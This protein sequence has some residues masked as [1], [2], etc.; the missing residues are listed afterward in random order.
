[1][2]IWVQSGSALAKGA[3][4]GFG[5]GDRYE[6]ALARHFQKVARPGT[7]VDVH[8]IDI[9]P[10]GKDR[11]RASQ[12]LVLT[13]ML[14]SALRAADEGY[15]ALAISNTI[16][17]GYHEFREVIDLPVVFITE[18]AI[19]LACLLAP[20]FA[21]VAHNAAMLRRVGEL[22]SRYGVAGRMTEGASL[23]WTYDDFARMY[24]RPEDYLRRFRSEAAE[25]VA[26][27]AETLL[28][29]GN[30]VNMFLVE[31][32]LKS[33]EGVPV[34]DAC[35]AMIKVAETMVDLQ[36]LGIGRSR[37]GRHPAPSKQEMAQLAKLY[38]ADS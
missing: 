8:G 24:E 26:R 6:Q 14:R 29:V 3:T 35:G 13:A 25:V 30:A 2:R 21:F 20:T 1:M 31:H 4:S 34:L 5:Y 23:E 37:G 38:A 16:D 11:Y 15:D 22:A 12:H 27:G 10:V 7:V 17:P 18:S 36:H 28:V 33:V 9:S 19:H 32:D